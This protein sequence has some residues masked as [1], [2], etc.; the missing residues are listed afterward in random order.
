MEE[1]DDEDKVDGRIRINIKVVGRLVENL[2]EWRRIG[3]MT[4][5]LVW[6]EKGLSVALYKLDNEQRHWLQ[7]EMDRLMQ[8]GAVEFMGEGERP[9]GIHFVSLVF[10]VPKKGLKWYQLVIDM[11]AMNTWQ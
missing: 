7:Q 3:A 2:A 8:H 11:W 5:G 10:L 4:Q 1:G 9:V 6:I